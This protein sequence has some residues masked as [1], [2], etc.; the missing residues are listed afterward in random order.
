MI[1]HT[2]SSPVYALLMSCAP[3]KRRPRTHTHTIPD[4]ICSQAGIREEPPIKQPFPSGNCLPNSSTSHTQLAHTFVCS[5]LKATR[6]LTHGCRCMKP[7]VCME[8]NPVWSNVATTR[9]LASPI[10][11]FACRLVAL[12]HTTHTPNHNPYFTKPRPS[13]NHFSINP[14]EV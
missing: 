1:L 14:I 6:F 13:T 3:C 10:G 2:T 9:C 5:P 8:S 7:W 12:H 4:T 11:V